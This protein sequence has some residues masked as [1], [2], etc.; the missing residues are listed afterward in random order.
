ME[1]G[2]NDNCECKKKESEKK[3]KESRMA[4]R[5]L[6]MRL[7]KVRRSRRSE[8]AKTVGRPSERENNGQH[9]NGKATAKSR[10]RRKVKD[11]RC[12]RKVAVIRC[13]FLTFQRK[14]WSDVEGGEK[15]GR[16]RG[17]R[18]RKPSTLSLELEPGDE[19]SPVKDS[20]EW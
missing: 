1:D 13:A 10:S 7:N 12:L 9:I 16:G 17:V 11:E 15:G 14:I 18:G 19:C 8:K 2:P 4:L 5:E 20:L 3:L 6:V